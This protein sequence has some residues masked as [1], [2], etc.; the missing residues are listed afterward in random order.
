M[1]FKD[2]PAE[3]KASRAGREGGEPVVPP[4]SFP[5]GAEGVHPEGKGRLHQGRVL[6]EGIVGAEAEAL[7]ERG[8][9]GGAALPEHPVEGA[10]QAARRGAPVRAPVQEPDRPRIRGIGGGQDQVLPVPQVPIPGHGPFPEDFRGREPP[11]VAQ[12]ARVALAIGIQKGPHDPQPGPLTAEVLAVAGLGTV[13]NDPFHIP[14]AGVEKEADHGLLIIGIAASVRLDDD[15]QPLRPGG[16]PG[17]GTGG[18]DQ[19]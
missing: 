2:I 19:G 10:P 14:L 7:L 6:P 5:L 4:L 16:R 12:E 13:G 9:P 3:V 8:V 15:P 17:A 18:L 1:P 11:V